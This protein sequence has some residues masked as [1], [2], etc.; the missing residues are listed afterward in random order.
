MFN[1][2]SSARHLAYYLLKS[3]VSVVQGLGRA[4]PACSAACRTTP[5][6]SAVGWSSDLTVSR[7]HSLC[8]LKAVGWVCARLQPFVSPFIASELQRVVHKAGTFKVQLWDCH[9]VLHNEIYSAPYRSKT[10]AE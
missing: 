5:N 4:A 3:S 10:S 7:E 9:F 8:L 1:Y 2:S 6:L